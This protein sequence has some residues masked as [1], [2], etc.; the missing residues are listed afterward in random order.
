MNRIIQVNLRDRMLCCGSV[1]EFCLDF[2][3]LSDFFA[4]NKQSSSLSKITPDL[5]KNMSARDLLNLHRLLRLHDKPVLSDNKQLGVIVEFGMEY[6]VDS[7]SLYSDAQGGWYSSL[8]KKM[9]EF[10]LREKSVELFDKFFAAAHRGV[11]HSK[12]H[13][14]YIPPPPQP[15]NIQINFVSAM[16]NSYALGPSRSVASDGIAGPII[17]YAIE[18]QKIL[19]GK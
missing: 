1:E 14:T 3:G 17:Y 10:S 16:G 9:I 11:S 19:L 12:P 18:M 6:G 2:P 15:N 8:E 5:I 4:R 13:P 7:L